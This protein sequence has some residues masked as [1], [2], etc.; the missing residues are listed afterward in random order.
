MP[1]LEPS[2]IT[3]SL[4][5]FTS[6]LVLIYCNKEKLFGHTWFAALAVSF[7]I[8][9]SI[10]RVNPLAVMN[11]S[12]AIVCILIFTPAIFAASIAINPPLGVCEWTISGFSCLKKRYISH[13]ERRSAK[14][15]I[16]LVIGMIT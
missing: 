10:L 11:R 3:S 16:F 15:V 4:A 7:S 5:G 1:L 2:P 8:D 14:G 6:L 13:K 9:T 12:P